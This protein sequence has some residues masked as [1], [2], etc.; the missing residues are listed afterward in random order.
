MSGRKE[1]VRSPGFLKLSRDGHSR[2]FLR[3]HDLGAWRGAVARRCTKVF[4]R[5]AFRKLIA[6][7]GV[8]CV[9]HRHVTARECA[10]VEVQQFDFETVF[11]A[12]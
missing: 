10:Y 3:A 7:E 9:P 1:T 11:S 2:S 5:V 6:I 4:E 8:G 12:K